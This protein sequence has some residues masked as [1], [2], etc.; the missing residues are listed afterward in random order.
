M[1]VVTLMMTVM[2]TMIIVTWLFTF[3]FVD[4]E[5]ILHELISGQDTQEKVEQGHS[6]EKNNAGIVI[7]HSPNSSQRNSETPS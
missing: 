5:R 4:G 3:V 2:M 7:S 1:I 6:T